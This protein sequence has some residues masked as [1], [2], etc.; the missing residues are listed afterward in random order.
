MVRDEW[1]DMHGRVGEAFWRNAANWVVA[2]VQFHYTNV[3]GPGD[4]VVIVPSVAAR[5][6]AEVADL[7]EA[8]NAA[9]DEAERH[10]AELAQEPAA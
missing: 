8:V 6:A 4:A 10:L 7:R 9:C 2:R 3:I 1:R 5:T